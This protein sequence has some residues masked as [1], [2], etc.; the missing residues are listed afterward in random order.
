MLSALLGL[1]GGLAASAFSA[2]SQEKTNERQIDLSREQMDF[3]ERM[4][5]TAH[6]RAVADLRAAGLNPLLALNN[7]ASTPAGSMATLENPGARI[8]EG[9][10]NSARTFMEMRANKSLLETQRTQQV[11]NSAQA[12]KA[13]AEARLAR[14]SATRVVA[15]TPKSSAQSRVGEIV[16][17]GLDAIDGIAANSA[18]W[19][20]EKTA[21]L[22]VPR[23]RK[24]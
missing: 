21:G 15:E 4:S 17:R 20:G 11:L 14:A 9:V 5:S 22:R 24:N 19:L 23:F 1:A 10:T 6:Q 12:A 13:K 8:G 16:T 7:G 3:Q 2:R 18:K